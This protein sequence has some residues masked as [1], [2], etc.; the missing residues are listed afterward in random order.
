MMGRIL[1]SSKQSGIIFKIVRDLM[2][3][4]HEQMVF[5]IQIIPL[6]ELFLNVFF[7]KND[8]VFQ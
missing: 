8:K 4:S 1:M 2:V 5:F 6:D 7:S 3:I